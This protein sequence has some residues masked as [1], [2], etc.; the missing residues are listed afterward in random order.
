MTGE[1][2]HRI[3]IDTNGIVSA[4]IYPES[5]PGQ[6]LNLV[7]TRHRL[8]MSMD[9]AAEITEVMRR[10]K[11]DRFLRRQLR[12]EVVANLIRESEF[13]STSTI[14]TACRD[15]DDNKFLEAAVDGRATAIVSGDDDLLALN[16]FRG[17]AILTP[18]DFL[19]QFAAT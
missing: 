13:V 11:F 6:A 18:R 7:L 3:V 14:V 17:I 15:P 9:V 1:A 2:P 19:A 12:E 4:F 5:I 16:P 8:L 10:D